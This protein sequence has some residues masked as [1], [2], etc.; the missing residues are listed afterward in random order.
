MNDEMTFSSGGWVWAF[1]IIALIFNGGMFG[2]GNVNAYATMADVNSAINNQTTQNGIQNVLLSSANNN[3]ETSKQIAD[4]T[5]LF[6]NQNNANATNVLNGFNALQLQM[7]NQTNT[8]SSK[9]DTLGFNMEQCC[10]SIKTMLLEN[11]L[12]DT[13]IALQNA[14]NVAVNAEQ[15]QYLLSQMGRWVSNTEA[16][17]IASANGTSA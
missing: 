17:K 14:Q 11:R 8:L 4:Q 13:Q 1:L 6:I 7:A 3:L 9:L 16:A 2:N 5:M 10:C 15:S 12:Q